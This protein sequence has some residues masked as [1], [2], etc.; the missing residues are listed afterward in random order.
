MQGS[1]KMKECGFYKVPLNALS[2]MLDIEAGIYKIIYKT[3]NLI[4]WKY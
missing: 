2:R 3:I 4:N 1:V